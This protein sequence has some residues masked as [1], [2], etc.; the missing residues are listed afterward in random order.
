M[1]GPRVE[2]DDDGMPVFIEPISADALRLIKPTS[3]QGL[4]DLYQYLDIYEA[5][6]LNSRRKAAASFLEGFGIQP[7]SVGYKTELRRLAEGTGSQTLTVAHARRVAQSIETVTALGGDMGKTC[8]RVAD[9]P[10]PCPGCEELNGT[11]GTYAELVGAGLDPPNGCY[12]SSNCMCILV[13][14]N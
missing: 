4:G 10:D 6:D 11:E 3:E 14:I 12:G 8:I 9:G 5:S 7:G 2:L 1:A 13:P